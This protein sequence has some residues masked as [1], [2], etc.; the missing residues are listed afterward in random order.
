MECKGCPYRY[1]PEAC[2]VCKQDQKEKKP[3][4]NYGIYYVKKISMN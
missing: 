1:D 4:D 2:H 3:A